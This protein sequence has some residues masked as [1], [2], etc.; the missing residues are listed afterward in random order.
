[1]VLPLTRVNHYHT[2]WKW[3]QGEK[4]EFDE[5]IDPK[6]WVKTWVKNGLDLSVGILVQQYIINRMGV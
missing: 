2:M 1:M 4:L 6:E 3:I 5:S